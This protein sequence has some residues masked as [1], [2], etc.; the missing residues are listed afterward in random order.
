MISLK[1]NILIETTNACVQATSS[2]GFRQRIISEMAQVLE[3]LNTTEDEQVRKLIS[4]LWK[5]TDSGIAWRAAHAYAK[6][7]QNL[8]MEIIDNNE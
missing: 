5:Y 6:E 8:T 4:L 1:L 7:I 3:R 2:S